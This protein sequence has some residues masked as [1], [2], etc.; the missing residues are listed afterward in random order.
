MDAVPYFRWGDAGQ[1]VEIWSSSWTDASC[2]ETT[3]LIQ[4]CVDEL[5]VGGTGPDRTAILRHGEAYCCRRRPRGVGAGAIVCPMQ[6]PQ[7]VVSGGVFCA[8]LLKV[9]SVGGCMSGRV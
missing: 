9:V 7:E 8:R 1:H 6:L 3:C 5:L 2:Y 4:S